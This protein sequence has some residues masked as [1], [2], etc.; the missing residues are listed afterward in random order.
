MQYNKLRLLLNKSNTMSDCAAWMFWS[1][2]QKHLRV[3]KFLQP[4]HSIVYQNNGGTG[5][6]SALFELQIARFYL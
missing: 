4:H 5:R 2:K 6:V 3:G 1:V